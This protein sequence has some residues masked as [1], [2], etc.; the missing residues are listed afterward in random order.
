M[1]ENKNFYPA[2][3]VNN[4]R[5]FIPITLEMETNHYST[6]AE[7]FKIHCTVYRVIDHIIP[8]TP[9]TESS[10]EKEKATA[11][12]KEGSVVEKEKSAESNKEQWS[13][14]DAIILQW[15][16]GTISTDLLHTI[17]SLD[18][19]AQQTLERL[20]NIFQDNKASCVVH[21]EN[22]FT[23]VHLDDFPNISAYYQ[24]LKMIADR[25]SNVGSPVSNQRLVLQLIAG[26]NE[27]YNGVAVFIQ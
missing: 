24:E 12:N 13:R 20:E 2:L 18:S 14:L 8:T 15:I 3:A 1:A 10:K 9:E 25:L 11:G 19:T 7:L 4:I 22:Q 21:L 23:R 17:M 16:Y 26:L 27:N 5:N 6:W